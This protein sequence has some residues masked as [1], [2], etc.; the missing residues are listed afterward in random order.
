MEE[1]IQFPIRCWELIISSVISAI[2]SC[3]NSISVKHKDVLYH[4]CPA[5]MN[6]KKG[7]KDFYFILFFIKLGRG[8]GGNVNFP[9]KHSY[10]AASYSL[11]SLRFPSCLVYKAT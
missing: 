6:F 5:G 3:L 9:L 7:K 1:R 2:S 11:I 4:D 8:G 10:H